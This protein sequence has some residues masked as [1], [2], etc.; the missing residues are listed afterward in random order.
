MKTIKNMI[1]NALPSISTLFAASV[2]DVFFDLSSM[3][4]LLTLIITS[5]FSI[6]LIVS[7]QNK[8]IVQE[9]KV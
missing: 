9:N 5:L 3:L 7:M 2:A 1:D 8:E 4:G 6:R